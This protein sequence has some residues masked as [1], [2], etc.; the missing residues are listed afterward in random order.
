MSLLEKHIANT[1]IAILLAGIS[2]HKISPLTEIAAALS[3]DDLVVQIAAKEDMLEK[4][5]KYVSKVSS[6]FE[7]KTNE[8]FAMLHK[9][10]EKQVSVIE[11]YYAAG[12]L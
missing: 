8:M 3:K 1:H 11:N 6:E 10:R 9:H 12:K 2:S 5:F 4:L 7:E